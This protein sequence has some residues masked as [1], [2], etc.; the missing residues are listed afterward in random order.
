MSSDVRQQAAAA[1][2]T[3]AS[4]AV[5]LGPADPAL[6]HLAEGLRHRLA[7]EAI[8]GTVLCDETSSDDYTLFVHECAITEGAANGNQTQR[9]R[10]IMHSQL[11]RVDGDGTA[12][13]VS[14]DSLVKRVASRRGPRPPR[15]PGRR[16]SGASPG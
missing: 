2:K 8:Q 4:E 11:I 12:R 6:R 7:A 16:A 1:G 15:L 3:R 13:T 9:P 10:R 14:W 5:M